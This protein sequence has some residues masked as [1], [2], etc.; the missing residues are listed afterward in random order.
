M[1]NFIYKNISRFI[2]LVLI[3]I[4]IL[5]NIQFSVYVNPFIYILFILLMP[6]E[7][8]NWLIL[9]S[10]FLLGMTIDLFSNTIGMHASAT[11]FMAFLRP[12]VL[13]LL[14]PREGYEPGTFPRLY[15]F[16]FSWFLSYSVILVSF[17]HLFLFY[18][19]VF[20]FAD[21][22]S[23]LIRVIFSTLFSMVIIILSQYFI[24]RK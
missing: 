19:E 1:I 20:R 6:F 4:L 18:I 24:Y 8:P 22:F 2:I 16:G 21:F 11:V 7:T 23:T 15:Y 9:L 3:Q 17:H 14:E 10:G 12:Y 13:K 5:N